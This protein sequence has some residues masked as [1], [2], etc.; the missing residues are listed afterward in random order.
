V[1]TKTCN[2]Q[3]CNY[4]WGSPNNYGVCSTICGNGIQT[5]ISGCYNAPTGITYPFNPMYTCLTAVQDSK[6]TGTKPA[7]T[8]VK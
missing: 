8:Q 7:L 2:T 6:C 5:R 3:S 4:Q 1:S